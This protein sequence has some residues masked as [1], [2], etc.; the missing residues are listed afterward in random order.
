[1][2]DAKRAHQVGRETLA[3]L[4]QQI[5]ERLVGALEQRDPELLSKLSEVGV[6]RRSW[7]E[8]PGSGPMSEPPVEV[9]QRL[10]ERSVE[11]RPSIL[12]SL[13]LSTIQLLAASAGDRVSSE[14]GIPERLVVVFTDLEGFTRFT[15]QSGDEA[16][17]SLLA[18]HH[19]AVGPVVRSR[20]GR[21]I[22]WLG[23]GLLLTFLEAEAAVLA[24]LEMVSLAPE[25][26]RLRVGAHMGEVIMTRDDIIGH[27][28]NV[29]ARVAEAAKGGEVLV[30]SEVRKAIEG[31]LPG[32]EFS[33][34][35]RRRFK[36]LEEPIG[37]CRATV[38]AG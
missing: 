7:V 14:G 4:R 3:G 8:A 1:M 6:V 9:V 25:P 10:L 37:V 11:R 17:G 15:A 35:R 12:A 16:A 2:P 19:R 18:E 20:G 32:V 28:V 36:G 38:P 30:S 31:D 5:A 27:T 22:K 21:V 34:V 29:A 13:G 23:D 33:R 24:G 26:L